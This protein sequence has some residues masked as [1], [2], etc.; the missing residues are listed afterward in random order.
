[1]PSTI[2]LPH[3]I[4]GGLILF[5]LLRFLGIIEFGFY[6]FSIYLMIIGGFGSS[7][8]YID[9]HRPILLFISSL[10][11]LTGIFLLI[12]NSFVFTNESSAY[13]PVSLF[14]LGSVFLILYI[15][16]QMKKGFAY[17]AAVFILSGVVVFFLNRKF[18]PHHF[19]ESLFTLLID[20]WF[21]F[22]LIILILFTFLAGRK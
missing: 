16:N 11:F 9:R 12:L 6:D 5:F 19:F 17:A 4:I 14:I 22:I 1:M 20:Q 8:F 21:I 13:F 18:T 15:D 7:I 2:K 10:I 3:I